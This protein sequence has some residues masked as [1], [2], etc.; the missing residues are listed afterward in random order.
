MF[1]TQHPGWIIAIFAVAALVV[2]AIG[3]IQLLQALIHFNQRLRALQAA[4]LFA[5]LDVLQMRLARLQEIQPKLAALAP[6]VSAATAT[7]RDALKSAPLGA[8]IRAVRDAGADIRELADDL[9]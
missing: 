3:G 5:D 4:P 8:G 7:L 6:R 1:L 2:L 9:R